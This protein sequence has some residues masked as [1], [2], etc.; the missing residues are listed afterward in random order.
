MSASDATVP[1]QAYTFPPST[2]N[3]HAP[4]GAL[5]SRDSGSN[6]SGSNLEAP[7]RLTKALVLSVMSSV[8]ASLNIEF[9][10]TDIADVI[11][12]DE[13]GLPYVQEIQAQPEAT[14]VGRSSSRGAKQRRPSRGEASKPGVA[15]ANGLNHYRLICEACGHI[16]IAVVSA[17]LKAVQEAHEEN[18]RRFDGGGGSAKPI[19]PVRKKR[20]GI[21]GFKELA[22]KAKLS[23]W[24]F[25][26]VFRNVTGVTP[27]AYGEALWDYLMRLYGFEV[28]E[29]AD[30]QVGYT[31]APDSPETPTM[32]SHPMGSAADMTANNYGSSMP[33]GSS[34]NTN[35]I[36]GM[37]SNGG[38]A[39]AGGHLGRVRKSTRAAQQRSSRSR[40]RNRS[41]TQ[42][43]L[44]QTL[45]QMQ[46][47]APRKRSPSPT[48]NSM[49]YMGTPLVGQH[50]SST[51]SPMALSSLG[52]SNSQLDIYGSLVEDDIGLHSG[53][54]L[55]ADENLS[56]I[57]PALD[58]SFVERGY[59]SLGIKEEM[60]SEWMDP[61]AADYV[62]KTLEHP[63][64][65]NSWAGPDVTLAPT[66][67]AGT[68]GTSVMNSRVNSSS[69]SEHSASLMNK[70][71]VPSD[72]HPRYGSSSEIK[73][74]WAS[75]DPAPP[76]SMLSQ[77]VPSQGLMLS[78]SG[79]PSHGISGSSTH[80]APSYD[81]TAAFGDETTH[82]GNTPSFYSYDA[83]DF[84]NKDSVDLEFS[85]YTNDADAP[86]SGMLL[87]IQPTLSPTIEE[88]G[89]QNPV[90]F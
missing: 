74:S 81:H 48:N 89:I 37:D 82:T 13:H 18:T 34:A 57:F 51:M 52:M 9:Q 23:P 80:G 31:V 50:G 26:R 44:L 40:S 47:S 85:H 56:F 60:G 72:M 17:V 62:A 59:D 87:G 75:Q 27:K 32:P 64:A 19:A 41:Q 90:C 68:P 73:S 67:S 55:S 3:D 4:H 43:Q 28:D 54:P 42:Q 63:S 21:L 16:V 30:G 77:S 15:K 14:G 20:G 5:S 65:T 29:L 22:A 35:L 66:P 38:Q 86:L 84:D 49:P 45:S 53:G 76:H 36:S 24:H 69:M 58:N 46:I 7:P 1:I 11:D 6:G 33:N 70:Q 25:H 78:L 39:A 83:H 71:S 79:P 88:D 12:V 61:D 2:H 10:D 8:D